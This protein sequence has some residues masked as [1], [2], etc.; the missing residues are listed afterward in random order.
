MRPINESISDWTMC[1][2]CAAEN[3]Q[4]GGGKSYADGYFNHDEQ[5]W[6]VC[7]VHHVRWY[8][9]RALGGLPFYFEELM[10][11]P[12]VTGINDFQRSVRVVKTK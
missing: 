7:V 6:A 10:R 11:F 1:P 12:E 2:H 5:L 3:Q 4:V 9:T 8:V